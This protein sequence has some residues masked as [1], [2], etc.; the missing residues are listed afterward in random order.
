MYTHIKNRVLF[1]SFAFININIQVCCFHF[2]Y[3]RRKFYCR[4]V[5]ICFFNEVCYFYSVYSPGL[6]YVVHINR[7][8]TSDWNKCALDQDFCFYLTHVSKCHFHPCAHGWAI[9]LLSEWCCDGRFVNVDR[10]VCSAYCLYRGS[11]PFIES[12]SSVAFAGNFFF[13]KVM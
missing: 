3:F 2:R 12:S 10:L 1:E 7:F 5:A 8:H 13:M 4:V 6:K 9:Y 11:L